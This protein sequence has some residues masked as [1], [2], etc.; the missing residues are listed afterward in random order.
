MTSGFSPRGK[1]DGGAERQR[2][3]SK[4]KQR[5]MKKLEKGVYEIEE[6]REKI[7]QSRK[8]DRLGFPWVQAI[9]ED[10]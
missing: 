9:F 6:V 10:F 7:S 4:R 8:S 3:A 5:K 2:E 1:K